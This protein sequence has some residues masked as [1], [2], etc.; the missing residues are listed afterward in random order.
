VSDLVLAWIPEYGLA[1]LFVSLLVAAFGVPFPGTLLLV[2]TGSLVSQ[3]EL[4]LWSVIAVALAA[5]VT[6]DQAGYAVGRWGGD[7]LVSRIEARDRGHL[8]QARAFA[9]RWGAPGIFFTRW[10][11]GPLGPWVN[12]S[13]GMTAYPW[14]R[15][16]VWDIAGEVLWVVLYVCAGKVF[17]DRITAIAELSSNLAW[18]LVGLIV[19]SALGWW[20]RRTL[21]HTRGRSVS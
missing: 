9:E 3:G 13:S 2:A 1:V 5:A 15:F 14:P 21:R 10:L 12:L 18:A 19:A 7:A 4:A 20:L 16:L 17:S 8:R 11:V 6:G